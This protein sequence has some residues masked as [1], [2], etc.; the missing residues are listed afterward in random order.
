MKKIGREIF[1][2]EKYIIESNTIK[3]FSRKN[4][5]LFTLYKRE[6]NKRKK[7]FRG[8]GLTFSVPIPNS[9]VKTYPIRLPIL[10]GAV[11]VL[12]NAYLPG[13]GRQRLCAS[14][15]TYQ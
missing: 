15:N 5:L 6:N 14:I 4:F 9:V 7:I 11:K 10:S 1:Y 12:L 13:D 8:N 2:R 3:K